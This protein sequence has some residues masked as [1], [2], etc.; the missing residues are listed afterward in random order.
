M[1]HLPVAEGLE[2]QGALVR[3][4][5]ILALAFST[6]GCAT[7]VRGTTEQITITSEPTGAHVSTSLAHSCISPCTI[8]V[9]R[10][11]EFIVSIGKEGYKTQEIPVKTALSGGGVAGAA[12]NILIGG[13][14][15]LGVDAATGS[16]LDHTP[17]PVRAVLETLE[18]AV[19]PGKPGKHPKLA[20]KP[21]RAPVLVPE[22]DIEPVPVPVT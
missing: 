5:P 9:A 21:A 11:D 18:P 2:I 16:T 14:I 6:A 15:G 19:K 7:I 22:P 1:A 17:N 8:T 3:I 13:V 12:G 10:K 20:G 4:L